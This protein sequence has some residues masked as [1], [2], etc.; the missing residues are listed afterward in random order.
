MEPGEVRGIPA[1]IGRRPLGVQP[2]HR[3]V[4]PRMRPRLPTRRTHQAP[5]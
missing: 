1:P 2:T 4:L 5:V 3:G